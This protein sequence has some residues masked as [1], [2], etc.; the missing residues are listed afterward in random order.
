[1]RLRSPQLSEGETVWTIKQ[2]MHVTSRYGYVHAYVLNRCFDQLCTCILHSPLMLVLNS[3][4]LIFMSNRILLQLVASR[5]GCLCPRLHRQLDDSLNCLDTIWSER[6][7]A[8]L[9]RLMQRLS[10]SR[11]LSFLRLVLRNRT[12]HR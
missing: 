5:H 8:L 6:Q 1:M 12:G 2:F 10:N 7:R 4:P 9:C 11:R 3:L